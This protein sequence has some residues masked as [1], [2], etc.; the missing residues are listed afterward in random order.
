V[1]GTLSDLTTPIGT[2]KLAIEVAAKAGK[3]NVLGGPI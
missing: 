3:P 2:L 1:V